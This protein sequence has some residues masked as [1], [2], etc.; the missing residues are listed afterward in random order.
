MLTNEASL[1]YRVYPGGEV[2]LTSQDPS[3]KG[4]WKNSSK[5]DYEAMMQEKLDELKSLQN[6]LFAEGK[7]KVLIVVQAMDA[8]GK[9]GCARNVFSSMDPQGVH[10]KAFKAPH[11]EE[12]DHDFL[13]RVHKAVLSRGMISVFNRSHYEDLIAVRVKKLC[14]EKVWRNRYRHIVDFEKM[15][16]DEGTKIVKIFLNI[17]K[18]EQR[19]RLQA[20]LDDPDKLWKFEP[21]GLADRARWDD[22]MVAYNELISETSYDHAPWHVVPSDRKWYRNLVVAQIVINAL[23]ELKMEFPEAEWDPKDIVVE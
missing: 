4:V 11:E 20:R 1:M 22:F 2:D 12:L 14:P 23:K 10:V 18:E 6:M 3:D 16:S 9:D 8:G 13:W 7:H 15:L 5:S 19:E 17:S 21:G